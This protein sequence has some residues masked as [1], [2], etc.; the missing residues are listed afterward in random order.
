MTLTRLTRG[1]HHGRVVEASVT[2]P[3][4]VLQGEP[5][6]E[7]L[8]DDV[9]AEAEWDDYCGWYVCTRREES[10]S[11]ARTNL[12]RCPRPFAST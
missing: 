9:R 10:P 4:I 11:D 2:S 5:R 7:T 12:A 8:T 3:F 6:A 1:P